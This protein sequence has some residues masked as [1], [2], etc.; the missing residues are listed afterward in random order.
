MKI[1]IVGVKGMLGCDL[2]DACERMGH[3][4]RGFDLP[5]LDITRDI[6]ALDAVRDAD[7]LVNC[8]AYTAVDGA[9]SDRDTAFAINSQG[10]SALA[11]WCLRSS[12][13]LL[14]LSTDYVFDGMGNRPLREDDPVCPVNVYGESKLAGEIAARESGCR[15]LIVRSQSLFGLNGRNFVEAI[16]SRIEGGSDRLQVVTDQISSPTYTVYLAEALLRLMVAG[17]EGIV[18]VSA[19]G[20]CSWHEFA[21]AIARQVGSGIAVDPVSSDKFPRPARRPGYSVLDNS[22]YAE[23]T[24]TRMPGWNEGLTAYMQARALRC[25]V[26]GEGRNG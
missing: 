19:S 25:R 17:K 23:W 2:A 14:H 5:E 13:P 20:N 6:S 8:S 3:T 26:T 1:V 15:C 10:V 9:E 16:L 4:A 18:N 22:L 12:V 7:W 11:E 24:G 21:C